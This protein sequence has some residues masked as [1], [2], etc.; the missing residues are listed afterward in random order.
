VAALKDW[1]RLRSNYIR[2]GQ[3]LVVYSNPRAARR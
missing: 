1:N 2:P 3:R